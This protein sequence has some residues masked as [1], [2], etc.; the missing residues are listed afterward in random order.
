MAG[1][2]IV[3]T[4]PTILL[5]PRS[6]FVDETTCDC[7]SFLFRT[8]RKEELYNNARAL[9]IIEIHLGLHDLNSYLCT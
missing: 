8:V 6:D 9:W 5:R 1:W 2:S 3:W 7:V 4:P